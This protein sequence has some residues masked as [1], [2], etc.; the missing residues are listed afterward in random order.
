MSSMPVG[1]LADLKSNAG[2]LLV[3]Q[4]G[5]L[6]INLPWQNL[7]LSNVF[8]YSTAGDVVLDTGIAFGANNILNNFDVCIKL[9]LNVRVTK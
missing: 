9:L 7:Q 3:I 5:G 6:I 4:E 8:T 1:F 2:I